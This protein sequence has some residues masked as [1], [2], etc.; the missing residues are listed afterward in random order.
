M[1]DDDD[2]RQTKLAAGQVFDRILN[3]SNLHGSIVSYRNVAA[4]T[5]AINRLSIEFWRVFAELRGCTV[6]WE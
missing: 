4:R 2:V 6:Q 1:N 5:R 3:I